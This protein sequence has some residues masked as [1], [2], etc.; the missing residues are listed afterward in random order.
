M[1]HI[2]KYILGLPVDV[3]RSVVSF[4]LPRELVI[5]TK[6]RVPRGSP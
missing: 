2:L 3:T 6:A 5:Y 1:L 4:W